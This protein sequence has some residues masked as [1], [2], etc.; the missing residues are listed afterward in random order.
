MTATAWMVFGALFAAGRFVSAGSA[1]EAEIANG[2]VR[3]RLYLP[4]AKT[5]FYRGTRFDWSGVIGGL[6]Y[7]GHDYYP[8]WFQRSDPSVHDFIY[9]GAEIV[10]GPCTAITGPAEEFVTDGKGLGF[11]EA[12]AGGTFVKIGVGVLRKPESGRYDPFRLYPI[13]DGGKWTVT[14]KPDSIEFRQELADPSTGYAYEYR[15]TVSVAGDKPQMVLDHVL[16]NTGKRVI[17]TTV[18]NHNFLYLD[19]QAPGP[20]CSLTVPF[21]IRS[22]QP[23]SSSLAEIRGNQ[24][25]FSKTLTGEDRVFLGIQGFGAEPKDYDIRIENRSVGAGVR[26]TGDR[27]LARVA[28]W[29]I[30]APLSLEPFLEINIEPGREFTW[31]IKYE[32][33]TIPKGG[34]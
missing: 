12:K 18:Y 23:L 13:Q 30:R 21:T 5:G 9:D 16:R 10:A 22:T 20:D 8:Q 33:Y 27:P 29:A 26:I 15:K 1:P 4:D 2:P 24:I 28:L 19:R 3:V 11:D 17:Q 34:K 31:R 25:T 32:Y 7:A 14:R 6:E